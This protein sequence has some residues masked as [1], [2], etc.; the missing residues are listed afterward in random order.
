MARDTKKKLKQRTWN[1]L[2]AKWES[3]RRNFDFQKDYLIVK[4]AEKDFSIRGN[5]A[6]ISFYNKW[7]FIYPP[8]PKLSYRKIGFLKLSLM[9]GISSI[10]HKADVCKQIIKKSNT[11]IN[12]DI[13]VDINRPKTKIK[14]DFS[15]LIDLIFNERVKC[16][17]VAKPTSSSK[18]HPID[19]KIFE[20]YDAC[21]KYKQKY[22][23]INFTKIAKKKYENNEAFESN[24]RKLTYHYKK[25]KRLISGGF[26]NIE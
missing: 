11:P 23:E 2:C 5:K 16:G 21:E 12:I 6:L 18:K 25:A 8:N 24:R 19:I 4:K 20:I 3:I 1:I 13:I 17:L 14:N 15:K 9:F 7:G 26:R 22:G 10:K